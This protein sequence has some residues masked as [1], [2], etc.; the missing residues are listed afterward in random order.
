MKNSN[1]NKNFSTPAPFK[2]SIKPGKPLSE[3][4]GRHRGDDIWVI[5]SGASLN[6]VDQ[7]FFKNK[8][9]IG[10]NRVNMKFD[11]DYIV[12]K[13]VRGFSELLK[14]KKKA[15][16]LVSQFE[17]GD[18]G[19]T[20]NHVDTEHWV[21]EHP[22]KKTKQRPN[23]SSISG[24]QIVVSFST[25]TSAMHIAAYLGAANIIICGHDCGT[26]DDQTCFSGYHKQVAPVQGDESAYFEWLAGIEAQSLEVVAWLKQRYGV[27]IHSL[28]PFLN[29]NLDGH[30]FESANRR[31]RNKSSRLLRLFKGRDVRKAA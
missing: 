24:E 7:S 12:A 22:S 3:L 31:S 10:V 27:E 6:F 1:I 5:A 11:C 28:N 26:I 18:V 25:I 13:D 21:F 8:I 23:L 30:L 15:K 2:G 20:L 17:S 29:F 16:F 4:K 19:T 9:T 14:F